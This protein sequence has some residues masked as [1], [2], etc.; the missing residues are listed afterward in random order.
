MKILIKILV[1][2]IFA[3]EIVI[4]SKKYGKK[5][6][7]FI[8]QTKQKTNKQ[9]KQKQQIRIIIV[10]YYNH[11]N[12]GDEQ[13]KETFE[14][15]LDKYLPLKRNYEIKFIDCDL[16]HT[17]T[18]IDT[19]VIL[20]GGG[21]ILNFYFIDKI[22]DIFHN[23]P[24]KVIAVSVGLPYSDIL[25]HTNQL[26]II[27]YIFIRTKKD[28]KLFSKY[29]VK[30]RIIYLPDI[31]FYITK[32]VSSKKYNSNF[33]KK[34]VLSQRFPRRF[35][36]LRTRS[37]SSVSNNVKNTTEEI[38][39][40]DFSGTFCP[41]STDPLLTS[42]PLTVETIEPFKDLYLG[43]PN[44]ASIINKIKIQDKKI[45]AF[46]LSRHIYNK[47]NPE[48][49]QNIIQELSIFI[50]FLCKSGFYIILLP[51]NTSNHITERSENLENDIYMHEDICNII[52][53]KN[54][55]IYNTILNIDFTLSAKEVLKIYDYVNISIPMR[56]HACL[57]SIYRRIPIL[58]IFTQ[59]KIRN[60]LLDINWIHS[61]ELPK[62]H[63]DVPITICQQ[64]L[65][66]KFQNL[67]MDFHTGRELLNI[68]CN[69]LEQNLQKSI[70]LLISA[71]QTPYNKIDTVIHLSDIKVQELFNK[72]QSIVIERG[73]TDFRL[74]D[75]L[76]LKQKIVNVVNFFIT[77]D[78]DS[79]Y[80]YGLMEKMFT[81][82]FNY[83][84]EWKWIIQDWQ[85]NHIDKSEN[86][87]NPNGLFNI[88][89][90]PQAD[91]SGAHRSGW[92]YVYS[93]VSKL[94]NENSTLYLDLYLDRTFHW[95]KDILKMVD[96]IPYRN[97]WVGFIHHT[98]DQT[99]SIYNNEVMFQ[100]PDFNE[101]LRVCKGIFVLSNY[102]KI[103]IEAIFCQRKLNIPVYVLMHPTETENIP[104][105]QIEKFI[106]NPDKKIV[107][108]GGWLRNIFTFYQ[109]LIPS[110]I[111]LSGYNASSSSSNNVF[112]K[113]FMQFLS[114]FKR[115]KQNYKTYNNKIRKVA[116]KGK[117]MD[118]YYPSN[119]L[120]SFITPLR[121]Q[122]Q[123]GEDKNCSQ[124][125]HELKNNWYKH[126]FEY[127]EKI[128]NSVDIIESLTNEEYDEL[129]SKNIVFINLVDA[130]TV[131][132]V[133]ECIVRNTPIIVNK[134]PAVVELLGED[135][136]LY[137][138]DML[139]LEL[140][141]KEI[142]KAYEYL[143]KKEKVEYEISIMMKSL[144]SVLCFSK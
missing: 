12:L 131:N 31:S 33:S 117:G 89:F 7:L 80:S 36:L 120:F 129:L 142:V 108:V 42:D 143:K 4:D 26:N 137:K 17:I 95:K 102:L 91:K 14:Y 134:H 25:M 96:I 70:P 67:L 24:N 60:L 47:D 11:D 48:Y 119:E 30:E 136:P 139:V 54:P 121:K 88:H 132:T 3:L 1:K 100:D 18:I 20:L 127:L 66:E 51:F 126:M 19:D 99:F 65:Q 22:Y 71:I 58:P 6:T 21:D 130:S 41:D 90:I 37:C 101:S 86:Y 76:E 74:V 114:V 46:S 44:F 5:E 124:N 35:E 61:Y 77:G 111:S 135:Y 69:E 106:E 75:D 85:E 116:L 138:D 43:S 87:S 141:M 9:M 118:N 104:K 72:L 82:H 84:D 115:N 34:N 32:S 103:Q 94:H 62:N 92:Q 16:L 15:M 55:Q 28:I 56:F 40:I 49:Y 81:I 29:F 83:N 10:G 97:P 2:Y 144:S 23:R 39:P 53:T 64:K 109:L 98:F 112:Y 8:K 50:I 105:F 27:D 45:I 122:M 73:Y 79:C 140:G 38:L 125:N 123:V 110:E 78:F 59:K 107:H 63:K 93:E 133:L 13:Y 52:Q 128:I 68:T 113:C 57:F